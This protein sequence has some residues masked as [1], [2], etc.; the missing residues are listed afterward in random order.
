MTTKHL[1]VC[2]SVG[3]LVACGGG[4]GG[5]GNGGPQLPTTP[6]P[7]PIPSA[8]ACDSLGGI[9]STSG[10]GVGV[11]NGAQCDET[12]SSVVGLRLSRLGQLLGGCS[13]TI[14]SRRAVLTAAHC[15]DEGVDQ[16]QVNLGGGTLVAAQSFTFFPNYQFNQ[17][18]TY[19]VGVILVDSDLPR[20]PIPVLLSRDARVSETA[21]IAG[22]GRDQNNSSAFLRAGSTTIS[23]IGDLLQTRFGLPASSVCQG[24][25]GGPILVQ[26]GGTWTVAGITSATSGSSCNEGTNFYQAVRQANTRDFI[27]QHVPDAAQR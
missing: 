20:N 21:I 13:A 7:A 9:A 24:D 26:E 8:Q 27:L 6:N 22:W 14:I 19:D 2:L 16:V 1:A 18:G 23:A 12:R 11:L 25:S 17:P 5:G 15:L 10:L 4:G 3:L